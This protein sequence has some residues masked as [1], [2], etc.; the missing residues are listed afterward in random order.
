VYPTF[1]HNL[2]GRGPV[3]PVQRPPDLFI[4]CLAIERLGHSANIRLQDIAVIMID[5]EKTI[6]RNPT[7]S[8][9]F[10]VIRTNLNLTRALTDGMQVTSTPARLM[11]NQGTGLR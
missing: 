5:R 3:H 1:A 10:H 9:A 2:S 6:F 7:L 4:F 11:F 8:T